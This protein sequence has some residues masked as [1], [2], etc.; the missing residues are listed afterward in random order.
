MSC[1]YDDEHQLITD[2]SGCMLSE[3]CSN[4]QLVNTQFQFSG[5][6]MWHTLADNRELQ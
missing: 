1:M 2:G 4:A 3:Q 5:Q 6:S